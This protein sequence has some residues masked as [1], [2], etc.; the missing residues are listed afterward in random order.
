MLTNLS[1]SILYIITPHTFYYLMIQIYRIRMILVIYY[2][3]QINFV[4]CQYLMISGLSATTVADNLLNFIVF[5]KSEKG[6][7]CV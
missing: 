1:F 7:K 4:C 6:L 2:N 3:F 5:H